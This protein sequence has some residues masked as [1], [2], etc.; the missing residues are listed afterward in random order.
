MDPATITLLIQG[1]SAAT[2][3]LVQYQEAAAAG[4][5][6]TLD[7]IHA[8]AVAAANALAPPG[9]VITPVE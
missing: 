3:L 4:D 8:K 1:I 7:A 2:N 5:Q 6:A 9:A